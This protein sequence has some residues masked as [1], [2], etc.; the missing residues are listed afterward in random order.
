MPRHAV[1]RVLLAVVQLV[2]LA[3]LIFL[4]TELLPGDAAD[5]R[6]NEQMGLEEVADLRERLGLDRPPGERFADWA[7]GLAAG[8]LG[9]SLVGDTPVR[10]IVTGSLA[11]T[12]LLAAVTAALLVPLAMLLGLAMGLRAGGRLDR[13]ITAVTLALNAVPD[14]VLAMALVAV[15]SLRLGWLPSTWLGADGGDLLHRPVLLVLPVAVLLARTVCTLSR[16]IRAGTIAALESEYVTQARRLGV[17]RTRLV[18][19]HV[20]PNAAVPGV[21]E[22]ARTG[23]QLL[24]GVLIVEAIFAIPGTA[25][26]LIEAVQGRDVPTVQA[27]T[28]LLAAVALALNVTADLVS[29]RLAPRSEVLR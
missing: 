16:Q 21:Q 13:A 7:S 2:L 26:A 27:L 6:F 1:R 17:P 12:A 29:Q 19:R 18:L 24:G 14:F 20:L 11:A 8:D 10:E 23:D 25:T 22:L 15:F 3:V 5:A 4:L 9:T 28:L